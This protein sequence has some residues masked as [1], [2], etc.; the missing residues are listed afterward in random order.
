M[1]NHTAMTVLLELSSDRD[2]AAIASNKMDKAPNSNK[3][4]QIAR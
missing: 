4:S 3:G 1:S 2:F